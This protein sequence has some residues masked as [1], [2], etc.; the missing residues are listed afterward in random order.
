[1]IRREFLICLIVTIPVV[2]AAA[3]SAQQPTEIVLRVEGMI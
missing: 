2:S 1:M 3:L